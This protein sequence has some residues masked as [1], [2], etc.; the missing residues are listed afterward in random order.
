MMEKLFDETLIPRLKS[1]ESVEWYSLPEHIEAARAAMNGI[2]LDPASCGLANQTVKATRYYSKEDDGLQQVWQAQSV[3]LNPPYCG[4]QAKWVYKLISEYEDGH[5]KQAILLVNAAT[6]TTWFQRLY[7]FSICFVRGRIHFR[8]PS[9]GKDWPV[10]GNAF[11][12][13]GVDDT[14][15]VEVFSRFGAVVRSVGVRIETLKLW[16]EEEAS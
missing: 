12:Y 13:F 11:V 1:K 15:F 2:E 16:N 7:D 3:W 4:E 10:M 5:V 14:R 9:G 8:S 6:E